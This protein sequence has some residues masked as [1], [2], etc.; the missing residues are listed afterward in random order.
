MR[1]LELTNAQEIQLAILSRTLIFTEYTKNTQVQ[2]IVTT[3]INFRVV[4]YRVF[5]LQSRA[6]SKVVTFAI[7]TE[8]VHTIREEIGGEVAKLKLARNF[9]GLKDSRKKEKKY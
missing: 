9:S 5:P 4:R 1:S 7:S 3:E 8:C 2:I 6:M